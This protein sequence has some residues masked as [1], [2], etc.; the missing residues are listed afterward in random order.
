MFQI[1]DDLSIYVTRGDMVFLKI[2]AQNNGKPYTFKAGEVLRVKVFGKKDCETVERQQDFPVYEATQAVDIVL[3]GAFTKIGEVISKPKDY[4]Y[5]VELNPFDNP[6]TIIGYDEDGPKLF[7]LF[8]EGADVPEYVP[9]PEVIKVIDTELDMTSERPI[10]N[11]GIARAFANLQA[12][13]QATHEAVAAVNVT[14]QM[15]YAIGDGVS[16]DTEA[17]QNVLA[18]GKCVFLPEGV[19]ITNEPLYVNVNKCSL[20]GNSSRSVI[21][22]GAS[23]P[24]G[25]AVIT[26]YSDGGVFEDRMNRERAHGHFSVVGR[27]KLCDGVRIGGKVGTAYEGHVESSIFENILVDQCNAAFLWGAHAYKNTM[28][29]CDSHDNNYSLKTTDDITDT[30]EVFTCINCGFWSGVM[31][32]ADCG[33]LVLNACTIHT[34]AQQT[35]GGMAYGHYFLNAVVTFQNCHIEAILRTQAECD[36][37]RPTTFYAMNSVLNF[38]ECNA[39]VTGYYMTLSQPMFVDLSSSSVNH[40][41]FINGGRWKYYLG[42]VKCDLLT[43]GHVE[44]S[45]VMLKY[46]YD[47]ITLPYKIY[48]HTKILSPNKKG[49]Y[50]YYYG[51]P[52]DILAEMTFSDTG[53]VE[54]TKSDGTK[55][56]A[57]SVIIS[58]P[59]WFSSPAIGFYRKVDVSGKKTCKMLGHYFINGGDGTFNCT[60]TSD[61]TAPGILMF[62]DMYDNFIPWGDPDNVNTWAEGLP[63]NE[64]NMDGKMLTAGGRAIAIPAGAKYAYIGFDLR[65]AGGIPTSSVAV[66]STMTYEFL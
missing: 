34:K 16:D 19:Y 23:F 22:A 45:N 7:R 62:A 20:R 39:V 9:D 30:G 28:F 40:G 44:F 3:D 1:N 43:L 21:K 60:L 57:R 54:W 53:A 58:F 26:F 15:F 14:P 31:Y 37:P 29:Q 2:K 8:P 27:D 25:E 6:I 55:E 38:N 11:Q 47:G 56:I 51:I 46:A 18:S 50:D 65:H 32:I 61:N 12:A 64:Y 59:R 17:L 5:E 36:L 41:I 13:Y 10:Q 4:W 66:F 24:A 33:E 63:A 42:R 49:G 48:D 35:V 52:D